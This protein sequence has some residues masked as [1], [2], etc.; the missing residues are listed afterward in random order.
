MLLRRVEIKN[1]RGLRSAV[2]NFDPTTA[3]IGENS[4]GKT[5]LLD[6][7]AICC[8]G[9]DERV[10]PEVRDFHQ[11][12]QAGHAYVAAAR[13]NLKG[14]TVEDRATMLEERDIEHGLFYH[15]YADLYRSLA[16]PLMPG[17]RGRRMRE[18]PTSI[19]TRAIHARSRPG[20]A[21]TVLEA[22]NRPG[23]PGV[24]GQ[25]RSVIETVVRLARPPVSGPD[26]LA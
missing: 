1:F 2:V 23:A 4:A 18:R 7:I 3:L 16:G 9:R 24:P 10:T 25:L 19:I 21:L 8:S 5:T 22:A 26:A 13:A 14:R 15:G 17:P 11:D 20:L 6:A 12:G